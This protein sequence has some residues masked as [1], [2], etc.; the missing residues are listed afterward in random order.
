[1]TKCGVGRRL[2]NKKQKKQDLLLSKYFRDDEYKLH[3][4]SASWCQDTDYDV[5]MRY[6]FD[7]AM[8]RV[9]T[10]ALRSGDMEHPYVKCLFDRETDGPKAVYTR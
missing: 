4:D 7:S 9:T 3:L 1:L 6:G 8:F 5:M 10:S 2:K